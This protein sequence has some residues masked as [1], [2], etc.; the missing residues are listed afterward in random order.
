MVISVHGSKHFVK[1]YMPPEGVYISN[2]TPQP[3]RPLR[4]TPS[5]QGPTP[6]AAQGPPPP[7]ML[8]FFG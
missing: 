4:P 5:V 1:L 7:G 3:Q 6:L 8:F 2:V